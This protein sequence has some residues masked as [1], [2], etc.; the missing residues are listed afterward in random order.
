MGA[1]DQFGSGGGFSTMFTV[2]DDA[3]WQS[4][5]VA[6]FFK[7]APQLPPAAMWPKGG[8][9]TPDVSA[10]GEGYMVLQGGSAQPVGG[11]SASTPAFAGMVGL[12]NEDR[13]QKGGKP[14]G[15][16]N[17]FIY[18]NA[19]AF[20]D[21]TKG[22][23]A[24]GRGSFRTKYGWNC[25]TGW[26]PVTGVGTPIFSKLLAASRGPTPPPPP[27]PPAP[28][29]KCTKR[30]LAKACP[31]KKFKNSKKCLHCADAVKNC[32]GPKDRRLRRAN[33]GP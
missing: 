17:P 28:P 8:R 6:E 33:C 21:V 27:T 14:M 23:N 10:L 3:K 19:D 1:T 22:D 7:V 18:A 11:T 12:L 20:T 31:R 2:A 9:G 4:A 30:E 25:T 26:D 29:T 32:H 15:F 13:V 24:W 16:L 5:A